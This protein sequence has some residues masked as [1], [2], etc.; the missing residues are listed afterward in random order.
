MKFVQWHLGDWTSSTIDLTPTERGVYFD[1][2]CRYYQ[3]E[4]PL[5]RSQCER[6]VRAYAPEEKKAC[7]YVLARFFV[8]TE[9]G[10]HNKR[11][12]AEIAAQKEKSAKAKKSA[13]ARWGN[14]SQG[15]ETPKKEGASAIRTESERNANAMRTHSERNADAMLTVNRKPLV[16]TKEIVKEKPARKKPVHGCTFEP[17]SQIPDDYRD[18]AVKAGVECP[19]A[20]FERFIN[21]HISK[22]STFADWIA[23]FRNWCLKDIEFNK[24]GTKQ[25]APKQLDADYYAAATNADG[26]INW[27]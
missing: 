4:G 6:I 18:A 3:Q 11:A 7:D 1:L 20:A 2:L 17:Y 15:V 23:A 27:G 9:D 22:G 16:I 12:D 5:M 26:S 25:T 14:G 13:Q 8:E 19:Q 10:Y 21:Y 24:R